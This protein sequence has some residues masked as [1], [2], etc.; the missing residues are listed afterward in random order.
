MAEYV[1]KD[2]NHQTENLMPN[3]KD[4]LQ[5]RKNIKEITHPAKATTLQLLNKKV[6]HLKNL[7][8]RKMGVSTVEKWIITCPSARTQEGKKVQLL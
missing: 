5:I 8:P 6:S 4:F 1:K 2:M 3:S 7:K